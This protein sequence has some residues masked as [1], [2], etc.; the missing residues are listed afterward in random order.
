MPFV[1]RNPQGEILSLSKERLSD[2]DE[3]LSIGDPELMAF[4]SN[5]LSPDNPMGFLLK[6]DVDLSRVLEDLIDLMVSRGMINFTDLPESAQ[7][8]L[9]GR[10]KARAALKDDLRRDFLVDDEH[11]KL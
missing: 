2:A 9:L 4:M 11:L 5:G 6:S 7:N 3:E 1:K 8:K 10:R